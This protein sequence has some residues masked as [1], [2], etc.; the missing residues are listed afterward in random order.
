MASKPSATDIRSFLEGYQ[1]T[2]TQLSDS[3]IETRRDRFVIPFVE[4]YI[5]SSLSGVQTIVEYHSGTGSNVLPLNRTGIISLISIELL[6]TQMNWN[7][8]PS[9]V[10]I[11][12]SEGILKAKRIWEGESYLAPVFP[13]GNKNLKVT[14]TAGY[15]AA[16][17]PVDIVEAITYLCAEQILGFVG[18][19]TGGGSLGMQAYNRN[20][21]PRGKY[22]DIRNDLARQ[23]HAMLLKYHT[24]VVGS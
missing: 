8:T 2:V 24:P 20:Y 10:E 17:I 23:A 6:F 5:G 1:I 4:R 18:A 12:S 14:Y 11:L 22:Q 19:R 9:S 7:I 15:D 16:S 13:K 21:G 3:W